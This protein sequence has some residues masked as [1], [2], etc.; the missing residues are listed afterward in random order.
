MNN[1]SGFDPLE[2]RLAQPALIADKGFSKRVGSKLGIGISLRDKIFAG[3][4]IFW[5]ILIVAVVSPQAVY[6]D[7]Y[8]LAAMLDFSEQLNLLSTQVRSIDY[9]SMQSMDY[10]V[11]QSSNIG[12]L[13][14]A[15]S[16]AA[17]FSLL[18]RN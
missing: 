2:N 17:I 6:E 14:A 12:L 4:G 9:T 8:S 16:I 5:L 13:V 10:T 11:L 3:A 7:L 15:M 1:N 18:S